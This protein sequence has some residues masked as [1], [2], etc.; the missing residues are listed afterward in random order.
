MYMGAVLEIVYS[1]Y[2]AC[3]CL[4]LPN[5]GHNTFILVYSNVFRCMTIHGIQCYDYRVM[6]VRERVTCYR[7]LVDSRI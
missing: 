4:F 6:S 7:S 5:L 1:I 2:L 3:T